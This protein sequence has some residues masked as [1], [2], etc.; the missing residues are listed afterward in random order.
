MSTLITFFA[1]FA[2]VFILA[3]DDLTLEAVKAG[4][5][6]GVIFSATRAGFKAVLEAFIAWYARRN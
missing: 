3:V 4:A 6:V 2:S 5:L 1:G